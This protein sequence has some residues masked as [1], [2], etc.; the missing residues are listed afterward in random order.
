MNYFALKKILTISIVICAVIFSNSSG[1]ERRKLIAASDDSYPPYEF[2]DKKGQ[3]AGFNVELIRAVTEAMEL[4]IDLRLDTWAKV[5]ESLETGE[6]DVI[7]GMYKSA[8]RDEKVDFSTPHIMVSY[9]MFF[10]YG[11]DIKSVADLEGKEILLQKGDI[12]HDIMLQD[13]VSKTIIEVENPEDAIE[14][15]SSGH[16]DCAVLPYT[17]GLYFINQKNITNLNIIDHPIE[18]KQYC[19]AVREGDLEL[20]M[21]LNEGLNRV[22]QSGV[23]DRIYDKWFNMLERQYQMRYVAKYAVWILLPML[24]LILVILAW[25]WSLKK[26]VKTKTALLNNEL[27]EHKKDKVKLLEYQKCL[28]S[29]VSGLVLTEE[30]EKKKFAN[31]LHDRITQP[32]IVFKFNLQMLKKTLSDDEAAESI[33]KVCDSISK[34]IE[35]AQILSYNTSSPILHELSLGKA[36]REFITKNVTPAGIK[37]TVQDEGVDNKIDANIKMLLF[38]DVKELL[39]NVVKHSKAKSVAVNI[40]K[41]NSHIYLTVKDDGVGFDYKE[42]FPP[43]S[44]KKGMGLFGIRE[45]IEYFGG[46]MQVES[47]IGEGTVI[48]LKK[49]LKLPDK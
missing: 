32:L 1:K 40:R 8:A 38:R 4:D 2:I 44:E 13:S 22:R 26:N 10:R 15:L 34:T 6:V 36:V 3:A 29:L 14:L 12:S 37:A 16:Y 43:K 28:K 33:D 19:F 35:D 21:L 39:N 48:T 27:D 49:P 5:R 24:F 20:L 46:S 17:T 7:S 18:P 42:V 11:S 41:G 47:K 25:N 9:S 23:Y 30:H 31:T 45:K